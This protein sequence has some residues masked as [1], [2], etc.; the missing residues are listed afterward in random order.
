MASARRKEPGDAGRHG[1]HH[2]GL[3]EM[4]GHQ[5]HLGN[6]IPLNGTGDLD[7]GLVGRL[8]DHQRHPGPVEVDGSDQL[9]ARLPHQLG[10]GA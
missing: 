7:D 8:G 10:F 9:D 1:S 2:T 4:G 5:D 6:A 3:V